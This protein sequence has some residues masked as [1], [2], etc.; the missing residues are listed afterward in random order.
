[1][2]YSLSLLLILWMSFTGHDT[3]VYEAKGGEK[4]VPTFVYHRFGD[5]RYTATNITHGTFDAQLKYLS[6]Q[7]YKTLT[8]SE[9][10]DYL[11][12]RKKAQKVVCLTID[13]GYKSFLENGMPLLKK[14]GFTATLFINTETVGSPDYLSWD[15][16]RS[17]KEAGIEI[18]N[19]SDSHAQFLSDTLD[20]ER[21]RFRTDLVKSQK[22]I[23]ANLGTKSTVFAYPYGE[24]DEQMKTIVSSEG[25]IG[26]AAQSSGVSNTKSDFYQMPRF[27][28]SERYGKI[29]SFIEKITMLPIYMDEVETID[30]GYSGSPDNPRLIFKFNEA[31]LNIEQVQCFVQGRPCSKSLRVLKG[32]A[33]QLSVKSKKPLTSRRSLYTLTVPD[34]DGKWHWYSHTWVRPSVKD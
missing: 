3:P 34:V 29:G 18:G 33:I 30:T 19:H 10:I 15:Q 22:L 17:V 13:D 14:Y 24:F 5:D 11:K 27:P 8:F 26:A 1:M 2:K 4:V 12:S 32:G 16:L 25:F 9:S 23:E 7:G 6:K 20:T 31:N 28:M 21:G